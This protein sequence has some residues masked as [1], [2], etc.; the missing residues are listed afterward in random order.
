MNIGDTISINL[1]AVIT[2]NGSMLSAWFGGE[3]VA[4]TEKAVKLAA[5]TETG[6]EISCWFPRKAIKP[7]SDGKIIPGSNHAHFTCTIARWF[8]FEGWS[9][10]FARLSRDI[11]TL[12][13]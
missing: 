4:A 9:A 1:D 5:V 11:Q 10:T 12:A 13:A 8:K 7:L 3:V 6:K 2:S